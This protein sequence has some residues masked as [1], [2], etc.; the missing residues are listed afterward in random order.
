M[1]KIVIVS[2]F[3]A[4]ANIIGSIRMT[5]IAKYLQKDGYEVEVVTSQNNSL[6]FQKE[7]NG[8]DQILVDDVKDIN[9]V[10]VEHGTLYR[11]LAGF[12]RKEMYAKVALSGNNGSSTGRKPSLKKKVLRYALYCMLWLQDLDFASRA[13]REIDGKNRRDC[14]VISSYGPLASHLLARKLRGRN[15]W[16]ADFRDPIAQSENYPLEYRIN[17][18]V[19]KRIVEECDEVVGVSSDYLK[20]ILADCQKKAN[21]VTNGYDSDEL[22][23]LSSSSSSKKLSICYTGTLYSG[24]RDIAPLFSSISELISEGLVPR[25]GIEVVYAGVQGDYV[26]S[27]AKR[28]EIDDIVLDRGLVTR[29]EALQIQQ[30][31]DVILCL[32]WNV[33]EN[34]GYLPG[35]FLEHLMFK[36]EI[37][38]WVSGQYQG[39]E[40]K[41]M[42]YELNIGECYEESQENSIELLKSYVFNLYKRERHEAR[43]SLIASY[44]YRN[45]TKTYEEIIEELA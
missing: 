37:I 8:Y 15:K 14:I 24:M 6:L 1:K 45:I 5:K 29:V 12:L 39:S 18:R 11:H 41:R 21:V 38:G 7:N 42:I 44:D 19:E 22:K 40:M 3:F 16:I 36:K 23:Y 25:H 26:K 13:Y 30:D 43:E 35:K 9:V 10:R 27:L 4:P 33:A 17:R 2:Y 20:T 31:A 34:V 32:T 28:Y